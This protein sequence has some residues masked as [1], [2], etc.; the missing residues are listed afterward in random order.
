MATKERLREVIPDG[1]TIYTIRRSPAI[2]DAYMVTDGIVERITYDVHELTGIS[3][4]RRAEGL[5]LNGG[6]YS[7]DGAI[8]DALAYALGHKR[9][10]AER[11]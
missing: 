3:Y 7:K 8:A 9:I 2:Y 11:L 10:R 1:G 5:Q 4:N 6:N